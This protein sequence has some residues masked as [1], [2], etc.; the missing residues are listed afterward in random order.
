MILINFLNLAFILSLNSR[1][2]F[3]ISDPLLLS[4]NLSLLALAPLISRII[5]LRQIDVVSSPLIVHDQSFFQMLLRPGR[6][7]LQVVS[8]VHELLFLWINLT[9]L[10]SFE[11]LVPKIRNVWGH[12]WCI[13]IWIQSYSISI[14]HYDLRSSYFALSWLQRRLLRKGWDICASHYCFWFTFF[15][16]KSKW[17]LLVHVVEVIIVYLWMCQIYILVCVQ[18]VKGEWIQWL[19]MLVFVRLFVYEFVFQHFLFCAT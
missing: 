2:L 6:T 11:L 5:Q 9:Y 17:K 10:C 18:D 12:A 13:N 7:G 16:W 8:F 4:S 3:I 15:V 14:C 19:I 1:S